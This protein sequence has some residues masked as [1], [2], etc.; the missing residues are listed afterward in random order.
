MAI[1]QQRFFGHIKLLTVK[2]GA[3]SVNGKGK[4]FTQYRDR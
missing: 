1:D 4:R 2:T 3:G